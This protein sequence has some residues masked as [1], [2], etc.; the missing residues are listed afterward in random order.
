M[1]MTTH[2]TI[3][4]FCERKNIVLTLSNRHLI[5]SH[6]QKI[7]TIDVQF[8]SPL[9]FFQLFQL[10]EDARKAYMDEETMAEKVQQRSLKVAIYFFTNNLPKTYTQIG[11][12]LK[13]ERCVAYYSRCLKMQMGLPHSEK[14]KSEQFH[15]S[16]GSVQLTR[17]AEL[18][19]YVNPYHPRQY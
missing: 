18:T 1:S 8:V 6:F 5:Y 10:L 12:I 15:K 4:Y 17:V 16:L 14:Q 9:L 3:G 2:H 13:K 11:T 19:L 7:G